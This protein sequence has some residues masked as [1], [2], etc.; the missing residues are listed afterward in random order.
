VQ[1]GSVL[2]GVQTPVVPDW[3]HVYVTAAPVYPGLH[4]T[5]HRRPSGLT[6]QLVDIDTRWAV[7]S[8]RAGQ[9][10]AVGRVHNITCE[11]LQYAQKIRR[12]TLRQAI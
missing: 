5:V 7:V 10:M 12:D 2:A 11:I 6:V 3:V 8:T 4:D 9:V 1:V